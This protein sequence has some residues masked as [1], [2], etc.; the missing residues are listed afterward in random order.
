MVQPVTYDE[1][2]E[3]PSK[4]K[5][6][7]QAKEL[8]KQGTVLGFGELFAQGAKFMSGVIV[9]RFLGAT[10]LGVYATASTITLLVTNI[11]LLGLRNGAVRYIGLQA[12]RG[13]SP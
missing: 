1:V 4:A 12:I 8:A 10:L 9:A 11:G 7:A 3:S 6:E 5:E 13:Y 2:S